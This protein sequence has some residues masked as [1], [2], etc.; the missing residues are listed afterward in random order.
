MSLSRGRRA[1]LEVGEGQETGSL[2]RSRP[3]A[4]RL[5]PRHRVRTSASRT[6]RKRLRLFLAARLVV[7]CSSGHG[8][9]AHWACLPPCRPCLG[10]CLS[11][12]QRPEPG[13]AAGNEAQGAVEGQAHPSVPSAARRGPLGQSP[14]RRLPACLVRQASGEKPQ[15]LA[16]RPGRCGGLAQGRSRSAWHWG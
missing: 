11:H 5:Q 6:I 7:F 3:S 15:A 10:H 13:L 4:P 1:P 9:H 14:C 8:A 12:P 16:W 2:Q